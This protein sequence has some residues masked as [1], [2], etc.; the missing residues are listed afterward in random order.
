MAIDA[1]HRPN[2]RDASAAVIELQARA[3]ALLVRAIEIHRAL[4]HMDPI[5][6]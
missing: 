6:A 3:D 4:A 2:I 1:T 5:G